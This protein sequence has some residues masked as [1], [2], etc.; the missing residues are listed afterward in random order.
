MNRHFLEQ[1]AMYAAYHRDPRNKLTHFI[2]VPAIAFS[3]LIPLAMLRLGSV[4]GIAVTVATLFA[5]AVMIYWVLLDLPFGF[6]TALIFVPV[7]WFAE[8]LAGQRDTLAWT[9][10]AVC[11]V[12]GWIVQLVGHAF[13]GRRPALFDN[14]LQIFI[15]PVF[16][17]AEI[18]FAL[19]WR[20]RLHAALEQRW[21]AY[22]ASEMKADAVGS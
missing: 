8:W 12:G 15:A 3:L 19:G 20:R 22:A 10:F 5:L 13:E 6:M 17:V 18:A 11:F 4:G 7:A 9:V 14:L 21:P 1:M 2:G 16:L